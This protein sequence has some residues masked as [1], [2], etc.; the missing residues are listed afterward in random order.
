MDPIGPSPIPVEK[1]GGGFKR[2]P[3]A[4]SERDMEHTA[5]EIAHAATLAKGAGFDA[6]EVHGAHGY[7][8]DSFLS[9]ASNRRTDSFGGAFSQRA[10][11]PIMVIERVREA[12][13][14]GY[15]V[16]LRFSQW[17]IEDYAARAFPDAETLGEWCSMVKDAGVDILH[18]STRDC[19]D[20]AFDGDPAFGD[21]TLV[22]LT[23][24]F[25][26]LPTVAVGRVGVSSSMDEGAKAETR[27]PT[28]AAALVDAG[29]A[30]LVAVGRGYI[31]NPDW[32]AKVKA[33]RWDELK[34]YERELLATLEDD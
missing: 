1:R 7:L 14:A 8:L 29:E 32:G 31:A 18:V 17:R 30:D 2:T 25:S 21:R 24:R 16:M 20:I 22:G 13:G 5:D 19:T 27:D 6:V 4:M 9:P 10:R 34:P 33:G 12:V 3:R 28:P 11:F 23:K 26:G 15:C